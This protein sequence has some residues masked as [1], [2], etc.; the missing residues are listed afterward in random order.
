MGLTPTGLAVARA[1]GRRGVRVV[2]THGGADPPAAASRYL[3][4][5]RSPGARRPAELLRFYVELASELGCRAA[6]LPTGDRNV[7]FLSEHRDA[8]ARHYA[9][10]VCDAE[11]LDTMSSKRDFV[12]LAERHDL[13][14]PPTVLPANRA[15]LLDALGRIEPPYVVKPEFTHLWQAPEVAAAG[16]RGAKAVPARDR[17]AVLRLYDRLAPIEARLVVQRM[18]VGP[19]ENHLSYLGLV[20]HDG[21]VR[22]EFVTR[23]LRTAPAHYGMA[24]LAESV[25]SDEVCELGRSI[26]LAL[27]YRGMGGVQL[28]RDERDGRLYLVEMGVRFSFYTALP[29]AC[30]VDFPYFCFRSLRREPFDVPATYPG[31]RRWW[32]PIE[33]AKA[34]RVYR[35]DGTWSWPRWLRSVLRPHTNALFSWDDPVPGFVALERALTGALGGARERSPGP[36]SA[37]PAGEAQRAS[38]SS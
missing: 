35:R 25:R 2:A 12:A 4:P 20:E 17:E 33:D 11:L 21:T 29:V 15:E 32:N 30:G 27:G 37:A 38:S 7:R 10:S 18:I 24:S 22:A 1:L 31:G 19:D 6:L 28:K 13:P 5:V 26:L 14:I 3:R 36:S 8:L 16:V 34:M 9:F 23:K